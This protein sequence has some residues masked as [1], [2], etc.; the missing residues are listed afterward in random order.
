MTP[1]IVRC[2]FIGA[3]ARLA[4]GASHDTMGIAGKI[5]DET[6]NTFA[7]MHQGKRKVILKN[8][9]VFNFTFPDGTIVEI[10]GRLLKGRPEDRVKKTIRR[11][12]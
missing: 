7:I 11:L 6:R 8:S 1:D 2:E 5:V 4:R 12:W 3:Q 10:E 9:S